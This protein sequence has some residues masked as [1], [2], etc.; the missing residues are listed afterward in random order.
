VRWPIVNVARR[1]TYVVGR[2]RRIH[3]AFHSERRPRDH[4]AEAAAVVT[5]LA[6]GGAA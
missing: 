5:R 2:D 4:A 1:V 6:G 3:L